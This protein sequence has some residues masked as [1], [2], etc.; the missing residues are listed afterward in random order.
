MNRRRAAAL[1]GA[2]PTSPSTVT[3]HA[4]NRAQEVWARQRTGVPYFSRSFLASYAHVGKGG[5]GFGHERVVGQ[6]LFVRGRRWLLVRGRRRRLFVGRR[7]RVGRDR[8]GRRHR[9]GP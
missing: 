4:R 9:N 5:L 7:R 2:P 8:L 1:A 6:R 3:K